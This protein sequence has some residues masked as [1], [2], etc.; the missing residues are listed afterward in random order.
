MTG[1]ARVCVAATG[2]NP[3]WKGNVKTQCMARGFYQHMYNT[4]SCPPGTHTTKT[5]A[6]CKAISAK[7][8]CASARKPVWG[9]DTGGDPTKG[10]RTQPTAA[11][12]NFKKTARGNAP[13]KWGTCCNHL[14]FNTNRGGSNSDDSPVC[15]CV[16]AT[17]GKPRTSTQALPRPTAEVLVVR[18]VSWGA[19][20]SRVS[21]T[22]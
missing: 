17:K 5:S 21:M 11:S 15:V 7:G 9:Q 19:E 2:G 12:C 1:T 14:N 3:L 20:D 16:Q 4:N 13:C 22:V 18:G 6:G 8:F 10:C